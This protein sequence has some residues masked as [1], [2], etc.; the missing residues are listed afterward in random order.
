VP[1]DLELVHSLRSRL[2]S[3]FERR[4][5]LISLINFVERFGANVNTIERSLAEVD[6]NYTRAQELYREQEWDRSLAVMDGLHKDLAEL[7]DQAIRLKETALFWI[8]VIE[9]LIV[10]G[11]LFASGAVLW[12]LMVRRRLYGEVGSTRLSA[13]EDL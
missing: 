6:L 9:W 11:A 8:Y 5:V 13:V 10:T 7:D 12:T 1:Q 3:F 4:T 2:T